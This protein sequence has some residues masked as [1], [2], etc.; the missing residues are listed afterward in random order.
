[1]KKHTY[2]FLLS[3]ISTTAIS[4]TAQI[5][6]VVLNEQDLPVKNVLVQTQNKQVF[7]NENGFYF[8]EVTPST[9]INIKFEAE[10]YQPITY[11]E[12]LEENKSFEL[13]IRLHPT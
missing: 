13:N 10:H 4:Q 3:A 7:T 8:I 2:I 1:M 6:G 5:K 9:N 12:S 11:I